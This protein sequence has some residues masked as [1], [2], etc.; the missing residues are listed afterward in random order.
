MTE[1]DASGNRMVPSDASPT[2]VELNNVIYQVRSDHLANCAVSSATLCHVANGPV[3]IPESII[4]NIYRLFKKSHMAKLPVIA[5]VILLIYWCYVYVAQKKTESDI[6]NYNGQTILVTGEVK[7]I[8]H[9]GKKDFFDNVQTKVLLDNNITYRLY[10]NEIPGFLQGD[11]IVL[12]IPDPS[13]R[14]MNETTVAI[15]YEVKYKGNLSIEFK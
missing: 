13:I 15:N 12:T 4:M 1:Y 2:E 10:S 3:F 8:I 11:T 5:I 7:K 14:A 9:M 6:V